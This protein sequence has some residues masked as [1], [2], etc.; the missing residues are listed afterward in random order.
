[1]A[2]DRSC[3]LEKFLLTL[4]SFDMAHVRPPKD[5][6]GD[7]D[8]QIGNIK[9]EGIKRLLGYLW[10]LEDALEDDRMF[11]EAREEMT[12]FVDVGWDIFWKF[13]YK[14]FPV[15]REFGDEYKLIV[16]NEWQIV[17][18]IKG[19]EGDIPRFSN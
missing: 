15:L 1:M 18:A 19:K 3:L 13:A 10:L 7:G 4:T 2:M 9:D 6:V 14:E 5:E 11:P 17:M 8:V 16:F 12:F